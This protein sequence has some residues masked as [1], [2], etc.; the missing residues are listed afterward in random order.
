MSYHFYQVATTTYTKRN[1]T[2]QMKPYIVYKCVE[3]G[4]L[5]TRVAKEGEEPFD[6]LVPM[7]DSFDTNF[8]E[9][10][11]LTR[12][13]L[14]RSYSAI[15]VKWEWTYETDFNKS[16]VGEC[17]DSASD[18]DRRLVSM[19]VSGECSY[20]D[21]DVECEGFFCDNCGAYHDGRHFYMDKTGTRICSE[22]YE[23]IETCHDCGSFILNGEGSLVHG[24]HGWTNTDFTVCDSCLSN[25]AR[26]E[27]CGE[28]FSYDRLRFNNDNGHTLCNDCGQSYRRCH[29]CGNVLHVDD[30]YYDEGEDE[31]Y[32]SSCWDDRAGRIHNYS[33]KPA[34]IFHST[35][36]DSFTDGTDF[37]YM[38]VENEI[39]HGD[40]ATACSKDIV[41]GNENLLYTKC[42]G[43]LDDGLEI[44][45]HPCTLN[46]HMKEFPWEKICETSLEHKFTSHKAGTCGLHVH[47][48]RTCLGSTPDAKEATIA[49]IALIMERFWDTMVKFSRRDYNQLRWCKK[50]NI[51]VSADDSEQ[52]TIQKIARS[53]C[54]SHDDRY[55]AL[56]LTNRNTIE[57]RLFRGT[58]KYST[59]IATLQFVDNLVK[60]CKT[61]TVKEALECTWNDFALYNEYPEIVAYMQERDIQNDKGDQL[62]HGSGSTFK[63]GDVV[64]VI[65]NLAESMSGEVTSYM[66]QFAGETFIVDSIEDAWTDVDTDY[67]YRLR[68]ACDSSSRVQNYAWS[69][70]VLELVSRG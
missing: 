59:L 41:R 44:V 15:D 69:K 28:Y 8:S 6:K 19:K 38:G 30:C 57:F 66:F 65:P 63:I 49:K 18:F 35:S 10:L 55:F 5:Y 68:H 52:Q 11:E 31:Y 1:P 61:H 7:F 24:Q 26:C 40:D 2:M 34:P 50:M 32:C 25:Y 54:Y 64:R 17:D 23:N 46:Y 53:R 67:M 4:G 21:L 70:N 16:I 33:Y 27:E 20:E 9:A 42:D 29:E 58:L 39:D 45:T 47:V 12:E 3:N 13:I 22:C 48:N 62:L 43:S 36:D 14:K 51:S 56:N 60:Y 37:V